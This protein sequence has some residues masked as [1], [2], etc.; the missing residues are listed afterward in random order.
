[1]KVIRRSGRK[2]AK[3]VD[4][5]GVEGKEM[6]LAVSSCDGVNYTEQLISYCFVA[7]YRVQCLPYSRHS[8]TAEL[9]PPDL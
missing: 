2:T 1:M 3:R 5:W 8:S 6:K 9:H 4:K 7:G